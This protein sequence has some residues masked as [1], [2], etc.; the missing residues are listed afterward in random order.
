MVVSSEFHWYLY[1]WNRGKFF[2]IFP[3]NCEMY[4]KEL[5]LRSRND[6]FI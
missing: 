4:K 5:H 3:W 2:F 1:N 6:N